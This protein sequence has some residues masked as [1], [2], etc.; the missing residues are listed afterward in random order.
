[1]GFGHINPTQIEVACVGDFVHHAR[2]HFGGGF[3]GKG[4]YHDIAGV[5]AGCLG[6]DFDIAIGQRFG[7]ASTGARNDTDGAIE[8]RIERLELV[9][10]WCK[11]HE[12]ILLVAR[13]VFNNQS[14]WRRHKSGQTDSNCSPDSGWWGRASDASGP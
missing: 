9:D 10:V 6:Q 14:G 2:P 12:R 5:Q 7:F 1:M 3:F 11:R 13:R 4:Q 8:G